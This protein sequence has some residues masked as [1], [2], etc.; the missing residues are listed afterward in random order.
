[1]PLSQGFPHYLPDQEAPPAAVADMQRSLVLLQSIPV[2][3]MFTA[4][5]TLVSPVMVPAL[6][7]FSQG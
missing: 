4:L 1:M 3:A 7:H 5:R 6:H 2:I